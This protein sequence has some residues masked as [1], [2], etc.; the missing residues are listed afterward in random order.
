LLAADVNEAQIV[1]KTADAVDWDI[2]RVTGEFSAVATTET[3]TAAVMTGS[4]V[5]ATEKKF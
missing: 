3:T 2:S 1:F 5:A 4:C